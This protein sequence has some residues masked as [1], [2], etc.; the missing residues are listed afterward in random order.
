MVQAVLDVVFGP[1]RA[2]HGLVWAAGER[3]VIL[4]ADDVS[5]AKQDH[6]WVQDTLSVTVEMFQRMSL[7]KNIKKSYTMV[8]TPGYI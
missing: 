5:I 7:E 1:Q 3:S 6:E 8:C 4:Y 2:K